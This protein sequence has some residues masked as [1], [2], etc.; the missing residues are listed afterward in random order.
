MQ[1]VSATRAKQ[2]FAAILDQS[3]REPVRIQRHERDIAV[4]ISAA[5]YDRLRQDPWAEFNRLSAIAAAQAKANG[6]TEEILA[7]I[8]A[9]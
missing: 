8:L 4:I 1:T 9:D 5:E 2:N 6:L 7:E 3:Q